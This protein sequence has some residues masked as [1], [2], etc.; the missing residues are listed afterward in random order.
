MNDK[1]ETQKVD[2]LAVMD[3]D[4]EKIAN[5]AL[6]RIVEGLIDSGRQNAI[7]TIYVEHQAEE[8][9]F[10]SLA[11]RSIGTMLAFNDYGDEVLAWF[12]DHGVRA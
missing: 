9:E 12:D 4:A 11:V 7:D 3:G 10:Q 5:A 1:T 2:V 8:H 6:R